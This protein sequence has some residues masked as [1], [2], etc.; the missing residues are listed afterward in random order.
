MY[1]RI[2]TE[3]FS[4][5]IDKINQIPNY[6]TP[7]KENPSLKEPPSLSQLLH[8]Y[9]MDSSH[10]EIFSKIF[11][12]IKDYTL[13]MNLVNIMINIGTKYNSFSVTNNNSSL[14][15]E[16]NN[17][18]LSLLSSTW[19]Y[20]K[21]KGEQLKNMNVGNGNR[22][23]SEY[24]SSFLETVCFSCGIINIIIFMFKKQFSILDYFNENNNNIN[25]NL[26]QNNFNKINSNKDYIQMEINMLFIIHKNRV[27]LEHLITLLEQIFKF[28][29]SNNFYKFISI[30]LEKYKKL[31][32]DGEMA[33]DDI[34]KKINAYIN[35]I[36]DDDGDV[37]KTIF[38]VVR[39]YNSLNNINV[40]IGSIIPINDINSLIQRFFNIYIIFLMNKNYVALSL[41]EEQIY[42]LSINLINC[43]LNS[44]YK[45]KD[46]GVDF[47][48]YFYGA[49]SFIDEIFDEVNIK[50]IN[51][52]NDLISYFKAG[53]WND[54]IPNLNILQNLENTLK[55]YIMYS[56]VTC[57]N[58]DSLCDCYM[59]CE[60][61]KQMYLSYGLVR[62]YLILCKDM[63]KSFEEKANGRNKNIDIEKRKQI[64]ASNVFYDLLKELKKYHIILP[65]KMF[66][67]KN[68]ILQ[69][70]FVILHMIVKLFYK[71]ILTINK[72][73][74]IFYNDI[75]FIK[76]LSESINCYFFMLG[77]DILY[78][79]KFPTI[80]IN[81]EEEKNNELYT[82]GAVPFL[83][84]IDESN[85]INY[86]TIKQTKIKNQTFHASRSNTIKYFPTLNPI[87]TD[88]NINLNKENLNIMGNSSIFNFPKNPENNISSALFNNHHIHMNDN[89][90]DNEN[91]N[92][93]IYNNLN[94]AG[95]C[96]MPTNTFQSNIFRTEIKRKKFPLV[97]EYLYRYDITDIVD[98]FKKEQILSLSKLGFEYKFENNHHYLFLNTDENNSV[99]LSQ[100][101]YL[102]KKEVSVLSLN[103]SSLYNSLKNEPFSSQI[104]EQLYVNLLEGF[105]ESNKGKNSENSLKFYDVS[106]NMDYFSFVEKCK[107]FIL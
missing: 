59:N 88:N 91:D 36:I 95:Y 18:L 92:N 74:F 14:I 2:S 69:S 23:F 41:N 96:I 87:D 63:N 31:E 47:I 26:N 35:Y 5:L 45:D 79:L 72:D 81:M 78:Y 86:Y 34:I 22:E 104:I 60:K 53:I 44:K 51:G 85:P 94:K 12:H 84:I 98:N 3:L 99:N 21:Q 8:L 46:Y 93:P 100:I 82:A 54:Q 48:G 67:Y 13:Y 33:R 16:A 77:N 1:E 43:L 80:N 64:I 75:S 11:S 103:N 37:L 10:K 71:D 90:I 19:N 101:I 7:Y 30:K 68:Y 107:E 83:R 38:T 56:M 17:E 73:K 58:K 29:I 102:G 62:A 25:M 32:K 28:I 27:W 40:I 61:Q 50:V 97:S 20:F 39:K 57:Y 55:D 4:N 65:V 70:I 106:F 66:L 105:D 49:Q 6:S 42:S 15:K 52:I 76:D 9:N 24:E 89:T